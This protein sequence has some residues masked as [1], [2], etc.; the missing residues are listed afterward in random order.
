M[1]YYA[2]PFLSSVR[3]SKCNARTWLLQFFPRMLCTAS[4]WVVRFSALL[5]NGGHRSSSEQQFERVRPLVLV[6]YISMVKSKLPLWI[7]NNDPWS[8]ARGYDV[9]WRDL[10]GLNLN[11][12]CEFGPL[13][14]IG[15]KPFQPYNQN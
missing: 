2:V 3:T 1:K 11:L 4:C 15:L 9:L 8:I 7:P 14:L 6:V 5:S 12:L 10:A 13:R